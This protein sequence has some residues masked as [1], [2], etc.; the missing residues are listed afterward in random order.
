[1]RPTR[2]IGGGRSMSTGHRRTSG[3]RR[4]DRR[5]V[6]RGDGRGNGRGLPEEPP[7]SEPSD[8]WTEDFEEEGEED[9]PWRESLTETDCE[10]EDE[11]LDF[12]RPPASSASAAR[13][14]PEAAICDETCWAQARPRNQ[15]AVTS[16]SCWAARATCWRGGAASGTADSDWEPASGLSVVQ[17]K[18]ALRGRRRPWGAVPVAGGRNPGRA[19]L[20]GTH[21]RRGPS[22]RRVRRTVPFPP[23][24][25][26]VVRERRVPAFLIGR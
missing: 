10:D 19:G 7:E 4:R 13:D 15:R 3:A 18:R 20:Q 2:R 23:A 25:G 16:M 26:A 8:G 11:D 14:G 21:A 1:M 22:G 17:L 24:S 5:G 6:R 9:E 12:A